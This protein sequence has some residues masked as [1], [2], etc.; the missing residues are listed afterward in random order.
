M[1]GARLAT[2][3]EG[4]PLAYVRAKESNR[5]HDE[6]RLHRHSRAVAGVH[7]FHGT[8]TQAVRHVARAAAAVLG[9]R[10]QAQ[11]AHL[12]KGSHDA[13]IKGAVTTCLHDLWQQLSLGKAGRTFVNRTLVLV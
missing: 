3:T 7:L 6:R 11:E 1:G 9:W 13:T 4:T 12:A 5:M 10:R 2:V 8:R